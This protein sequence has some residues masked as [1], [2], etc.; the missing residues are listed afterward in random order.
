MN[1]RFESASKRIALVIGSG[2]VKCAA[3]LGLWKVL[4]DE[5]I[6]IDLL[7]GCSGGS[8]Y[9]ATMALGF[10][11]EDC[12]QKTQRLWNRKITEKRDNQSI[13]RA[14]FPKFFKFDERFGMMDDEAVLKSLQAVFAER[15]F[16]DA[17]TPLF[18]VATDFHSGDQVVMSDGILVDAIRA[19]IAI[20]YIWRP[21]PVDG[22]LMIDGSTSN[23]MPVDVA[24]KEGA[25]L[26]LAMGF[27][28]PFP[29]KVK[30][31]SRFAFHINSLMTNNLMRANFSFHNLAHHAEIIPILPAFEREIGLFDTRQ[32]LYVIA[33]G[34]K[35]MREQLPYLRRLLQE[36]P[37][38]QEN[39]LP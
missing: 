4:K 19:S 38:Q 31:I 37:Q 13:L 39:R 1:S 3:A 9:A 8:L 17:K 29:R 25:E 16:R 23:P 26:I 34:E 27:E 33:Q 21:W 15:S 12:I 10:D 32:F 35:A 7:V 5:D 36:T 28:S 14:M 2:A 30:S 20:P 6:D 11:V 24:I 18:I 22:C